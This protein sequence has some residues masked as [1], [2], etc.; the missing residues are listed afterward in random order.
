M[1]VPAA[2]AIA[3]SDL[4]VPAAKLAHKAFWIMARRVT[5]MAACVDVAL[6]ALFFALGSPLLAWLNVVSVA[7]YAAAYFLLGR[8]INQLALALIWLEVMGHASI[9]TL[10]IGWDSGFHYY[11]LMFI[12]AIVV[13][14][15]QHIRTCLMLLVLLGFYLG[16]HT[17]SRH[18]GPLEPLSMQGLGWVHAFNVAVVFAMAAYTAR[19]YYATVRRAESQLRHLAATD[20]L[21]GL[22]NR[23]RLMALAQEALT[24]DRAAGLP[25]ALLI[26]DIDHFKCT[27]DRYGHDAGDKVLIHTAAMLLCTCRVQ[28]I[29]ARWGGEEFLMLLP[30][31]HAGAAEALAE[32]VRDAVAHQAVE[33]EG[34]RIQATL[35]IGVSQVWANETLE[36]AIARADRALY[37]SKDDGRDR[38]TVAGDLL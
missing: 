7:L 28:D 6:F 35:S 5:V 26:A 25:T 15:A 17:L 32:R 38:V 2:P 12:P 1:P 27:N 20:P 9:G 21:T 8:R 4:A 34:H 18:L 36:A 33:H 22:Y 14:M 29:V 24:R 11:L 31:T 37:R 3:A 19:F 30:A 16:L 23:R 13:S 10:L